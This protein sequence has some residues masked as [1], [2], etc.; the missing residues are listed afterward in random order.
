MAAFCFLSVPLLAAQEEETL[1]KPRIYFENPDPSTTPRNQVP[2][3]G[4]SSNA[5]PRKEVLAPSGVGVPTTPRNVRRTDDKY[6]RVIRR[7]EKGLYYG[8]VAGIGVGVGVGIGSA[9]FV[10]SAFKSVVAKTI[11]GILFFPIGFITSVLVCAT[12]GAVIGRIA[13]ELS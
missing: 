1:V 2:L 6:A 10:A 8:N 12:L 9:I 11:M 3:P 5:E 4:A 13:G 7:T